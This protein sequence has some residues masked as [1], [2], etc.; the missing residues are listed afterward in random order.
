MGNRY[1]SHLGGKVPGKAINITIPI[2]EG[3]R[4]TM[5]TLKVVSSDPD[6]S[7]SLKADALK[8]AFPL[9][10]GDV[11]SASKVRKAIE[12]YGKI[13]GQYGFIDFVPQHDTEI[14]EAAKRINMTMRF[15]EGKQY[16]IRRIEFSGNTTTR[17]KV[18]RRELLIHES[19]SFNNRAWEISMLRLNQVHYC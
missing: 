3:D 10:Q 7:L 12:D 19:Q 4:Y 13:Y 15:D 1:G 18:I 2:E 17:D 9:K 5:G 8:N 14:D 16:Y 6:K 11:F